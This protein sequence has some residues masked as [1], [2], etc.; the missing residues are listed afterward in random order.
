VSDIFQEVDEELRRERVREIWARYGNLIVAAACLIVLG[1]GGWR[2]YEW[3]EAKK[4]AE[5]GA[6]FEAAM[7]LAKDNKAADAQAAFSQ[8]AADG[9]SGYRMLARLQEAAGVAKT[10][11]AGAVKIYDAIIA[12]GGATAVIQDL[13]RVR[14]GLLL[15][16]TASLADLRTRLES[17]A[18]ADRAFR[19]TAR[20]ILAFA[21]WRAGDSGEARKWSEMIRLDPQTPAATRNRIE[22]LTALIQPEAKS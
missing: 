5:N 2:G 10:D 11:P 18:G 16:D 19:H 22:M 4:A 15:A 14:A 20:E 8:I 17:A 9:A 3:W 6:R 13:A 7:A 12:D 21:A 1:V